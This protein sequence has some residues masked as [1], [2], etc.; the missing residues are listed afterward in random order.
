M[1]RL[2][3]GFA[4]ICHKYTRASAAIWC[5]VSALPSIICS[6]IAILKYSFKSLALQ[7]L[8]QDTQLK[9]FPVTVSLQHIWM[10]AMQY[11]AWGVNTISQRRG[12]SKL[13]ACPYVL[14]CPCLRGL[15][16]TYG[17][18]F[19]WSDTSSVKALRPIQHV[20]VIP[21]IFIFCIQLS[22]IRLGSWLVDC[23]LRRDASVMSSQRWSW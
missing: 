1:K 9:L 20:L 15:C 8:S 14:A 12:S 3:L 23:G 19:R 21:V 10:N 7:H 6:A 11:H 17:L 5:Y 13:K 22:R 2:A 4:S 18:G 16:N